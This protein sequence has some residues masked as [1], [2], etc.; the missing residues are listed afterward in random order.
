[1]ATMDTNPDNDP[2]DDLLDAILGTDAEEPLAVSRSA[3]L[4]EFRRAKWR[5]RRPLL[6]NIAAMAAVLCLLLY[7]LAPRD[8]NPTPG[9]LTEFPQPKFVPL[10]DEELLAL[11]PQGSCLLAQI[12]GRTELVFLDPDVEAQY[13]R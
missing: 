2:Q 10:E 12:D 6:Q 4:K 1:M 3:A 5:R 7:T 8:H 9:S 13:L 11:F